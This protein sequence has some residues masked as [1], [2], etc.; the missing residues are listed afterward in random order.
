MLSL[1][2]AA[3]ATFPA[4]ELTAEETVELSFGKRIAA[5]SIADAPGALEPFT[6]RVS[7]QPTAAFASDGTLVALLEDRMGQSVPV[8]VFAPA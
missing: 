7:G 2:D 5:T 3:R 6:L 4:R 1:A 8:V